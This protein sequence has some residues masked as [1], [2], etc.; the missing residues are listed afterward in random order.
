MK[1]TLEGTD[2][3]CDDKQLLRAR[4]GTTLSTVCRQLFKADNMARLIG[5]VQCAGIGCE[6]CGEKV[7]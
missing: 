4:L 5:C 7:W 2:I 3:F 1:A 6:G